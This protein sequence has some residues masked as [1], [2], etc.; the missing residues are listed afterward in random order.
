MEPSGNTGNSPPHSKYG[1][2]GAKYIR[3][4][5]ARPWKSDLASGRNKRKRAARSDTGGL[6][7]QANELY[8]TVMSLVKSRHKLTCIYY[9][10]TRQCALDDY[11]Y[12]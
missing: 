9:F 6:L 2:I 7:G 11:C 4:I 8:I 12:M 5:P 10:S 3:A 1:C